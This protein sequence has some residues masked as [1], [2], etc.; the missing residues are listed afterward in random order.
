MHKQKSN[1]LW[2]ICVVKDFLFNVYNIKV[3]KVRLQCESRSYLGVSDSLKGHKAT[4]TKEDGAHGLGLPVTSVAE[5]HQTLRAKR[6]VC[7]SLIVL[8]NSY[9]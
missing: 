6:F 8:L 1:S 5:L 2:V 7:P 3:F 4:R 9:I